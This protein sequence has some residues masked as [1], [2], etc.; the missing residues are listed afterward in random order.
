MEHQS[1][2][3]HSP[4]TDGTLS[5]LPTTVQTVTMANINPAGLMVSIKLTRD[6]FLIWKI[7]ILPLLEAYQL[8]D[9]LYQHPPM[10]S[11]LNEQGQSFS[12]LAYQAWFI[13]D[14]V[15]LSTITSSLSK[16]TM[17]LAIS[18]ETWEAINN[19]FAARTR[20]RVMEIQTRLHN[21]RKGNQPL[22]TYIHTSRNLGD[23]IWSYGGKMTEEDLTFSLLRGL[24]PP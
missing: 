12:N 23:E 20:S 15:V 13:R 22:D 6:N 11:S 16:S 3:S 19:Q 24:Q 1:D 10:I 18:K 17:S 14:K 7:Q 4:V 9:L 21:Y 5:A 8:T 2:D